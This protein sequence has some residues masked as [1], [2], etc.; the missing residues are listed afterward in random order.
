MACSRIKFGTMSLA[1]VTAPLPPKLAYALHS[2]HR[3]VSG[4]SVQAG[5]GNPLFNL[6]RPPPRWGESCGPAREMRPPARPRALHTPVDF[7][8][9]EYR[10]GAGLPRKTGNGRGIGRARRQPSQVQVSGDRRPNP[11]AAG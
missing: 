6:G 2:L 7:A 3:P 11:V 9:E 10:R 5:R 8:T 4:P 1:P